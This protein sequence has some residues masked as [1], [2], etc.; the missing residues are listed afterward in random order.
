M[1]FFPVTVPGVPTSAPYHMAAPCN[2]PTYDGYD[3]TL[4]PSVVDFGGK[5]RGY[6]FWMIHTPY[7]RGIEGV[8]PDINENPSMAASND[9]LN[10]TPIG[11]QPIWYRED[12]GAGYNSDVELAWDPASRNLHLWWRPMIAN[13]GRLYHASSADGASWSTPT[14]QLPSATGLSPCVVRMA[15]GDWRLWYRTGDEWSVGHI[16]EMRTA[17]SPDGPWSAAVPCSHSRLDVGRTGQS[18]W[19]MGVARHPDGRLLMIGSANDGVF[20]ATSLDGGY[21]WLW[22]PSPVLGAA[23]AGSTWAAGPGG[24]RTYPVLHE[25]GTHMRVWFSS[26]SSGWRTGYTELPLSLWPSS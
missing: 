18:L 7:P 10:W 19:H 9:C 8:I 17:S 13:V 2:I 24:Y 1:P 5:W 25:N 26:F 6:R 11:P 23:P 20:V 12:L 15:E 3:Q 4:H 21:Q 22:H 16:L 14:S